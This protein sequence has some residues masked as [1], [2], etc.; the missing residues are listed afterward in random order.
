MPVTITNNPSNQNTGASGTVLQGQG[1]G[2]ADAHSTATYPSTATGT[3][4]ILRADGTNWSATT[5]TYPNTATAGDILYASASNVIGNLAAVATG[6]VLASAGTSTAPAYTATP[7]LTS[8]TL[9]TALT[10]ANGGTGATTL[11][12]NGVLYGNGTSAIKATTQLNA[13]QTLIAPTSTSAPTPTFST[14]Q[15]MSYVPAFNSIPNMSLSTGGAAINSAT[16]INIMSCVPYGVTFEVY[17]GSGSNWTHIAPTLSTTASFGWNINNIPAANSRTMEIT[18]GNSINTKN[19]FTI[20]TSPAFFV[21]AS[22]A[23]SVL[24][25]I[26][27]LSL[28]FRIVQTYQTTYLTGYTDY[29][30]ISI[31]T[32]TGSGAVVL[33][34]QKTSGGETLTNTTNTVTAATLFTFEVDISGSG[35]VTY[36]LNGSAPTTVASYTFTSGLQVIPWITYSTASGA[37]AETDWA[38]YQCGLQ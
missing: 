7:T 10:L 16:A 38:S 8:I 21:K 30:C 22:F 37:N 25:D 32:G 1:I 27:E 34:T 14:N 26:A 11:T 15:Y 12:Q 23:I 19:S 13:G 18:E 6:Q 24:A 29:A 4:T 31:N 3:G 28:G 9:D 2:T 36:K 17:N 35:V 20:G 33:Q 5:N